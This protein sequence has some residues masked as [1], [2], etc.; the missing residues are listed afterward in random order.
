MDQLQVMKAEPRNHLRYSYPAVRHAYLSVEN[1]STL[2]GCSMSNSPVELS[3]LWHDAVGT[4][5]F[6][7]AL[8][9]HLQSVVGQQPWSVM[10]ELHPNPL[11]PRNQVPRPAPNGYQVDLWRD[12]KRLFRQGLRNFSA[13]SRRARHRGRLL[14]LLSSHHGG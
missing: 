4:T 7:G 9:W 5:V 10:T 6:Q 2:L 8:F 1:G 13:C 11:Q 12:P 14:L 3:L